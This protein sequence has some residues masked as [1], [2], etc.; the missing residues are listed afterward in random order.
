MPFDRCEPT[1][2]QKAYLTPFFSVA[3]SVAEP[4]SPMIRVFQVLPPS[5]ES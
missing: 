5:A 1:P 3:V 2:H 4:A